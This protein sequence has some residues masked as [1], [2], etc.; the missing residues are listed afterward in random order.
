VNMFISRRT[1]IASGA[2]LW[3]S[4][5]VSAEAPV[6]S[7][8]P[9]TPSIRL[10]ANENPYGPSPKARAALLACADE[11][12]RYP[13]EAAREFIAALAA[14]ENVKAEQIVIG[15]GSGE[16]LHMAGTIFAEGGG[17]IVAPHP[18]FDQLPSYAAKFGGR[19]KQVPLDAELRLDLRAMRAAAGT[20][21]RLVYVCNPNNP[22]GTAHRAAELREFI[23]ALP[24]ATVVLVDEAYI[25][26]TGD[27]AV[28]SVVDLAR[29]RPNVIVL[30]TF[31]KT[32][33]L[34]GLRVGY[35]IAQPALAARLRDRQM[36]S[37]N[38]AGIR[39]A[40]ASLDDEE[41]HKATRARLIADRARVQAK[42]DELGVRHTRACG[43]FVFFDTGMPLADFRAAMRARAISI[44]RP[45]EPFPTWSRVSIG[46]TAETDALLAA[47][48]ETLKARK[49]A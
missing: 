14:L 23:R 24:E 16:L 32:H 6:S 21:T 41:H 39:A 45:F 29:E 5:A 7:A 20:N 8:P 37:P 36:T 35:A 3:F 18:T 46:T 44:A 27:P 33:G 40:R 28:T 11:A 17:E 34:A 12:C 30:R 15:A 22:S 2:A 25:D 42:L 49:V 19:I 9:A 43:N 1:A 38:V 10:G 26:L 47:L 48:P 31:S 13:M 4:R